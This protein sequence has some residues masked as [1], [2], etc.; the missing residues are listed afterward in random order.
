MEENHDLGKVKVY[1]LNRNLG[2]GDTYAYASN[3]FHNNEIGVFRSV[4]EVRID[5]NTYGFDPW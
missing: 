1:G 5:G 3:Y 4:F 2:F